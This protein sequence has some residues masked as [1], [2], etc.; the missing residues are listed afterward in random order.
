MEPSVRVYSYRLACP[1]PDM[2]L[3]LDRFEQRKKTCGELATVG[4]CVQMARTG[5]THLPG[6]RVGKKLWVE[7]RGWS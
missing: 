4:G 5:D 6:I 2:P 1:V 3:S 7:L